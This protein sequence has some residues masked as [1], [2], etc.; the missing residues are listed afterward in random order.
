MVSVRDIISDFQLMYREDWKY[1]W[2]GHTKGLVG[3]AGAF[4]YSF[5]KYGISCPNGSNAITRNFC[6]GGVGGLKPISQA[7]PGM[8]AVKWHPPDSKDYALPDKY[9]YGHSAYNGDLNDYYHIGLVDEDPRFVLNAQGYKNNFE[10]NKIDS[11][12][13]VFYLKQVDYNGG[14]QMQAT[15]VLPKGASGKTVNMRKTS[16]LTADLVDRVPAGSVVEVVKDLGQWCQIRWQGKDGF[17][18]SNYIEYEGQADETVIDN[19][20]YLSIEEQLKIICSAA[21]SIRDIIGRG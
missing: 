16:N 15:V 12:G 9:K 10:R 1:D 7:V 17:M 14:E 6:L 11:W 8:A 20:L 13:F 19:D 18:L 2:S 21:E 4:T 3:C 5:G